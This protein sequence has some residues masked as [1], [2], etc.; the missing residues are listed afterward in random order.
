MS[1]QD[2]RQVWLD[3]EG[4][5]EP[6]ECFPTHQHGSEGGEAR[7]PREKAWQKACHLGTCWV[8]F[9]DENQPLIGADTLYQRLYSTHQTL[10]CDRR[11]HDYETFCVYI[12]LATKHATHTGGISSR[13][14]LFVA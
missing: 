13:A 7:L 14:V 6:S 1:L 11:T 10:Q 9:A 4:L 2:Q 8:S 5:R 3:Q 12:V